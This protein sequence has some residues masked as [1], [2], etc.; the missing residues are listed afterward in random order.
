MNFLAMVVYAGI[1]RRTER[2][3]RGAVEL[4]TSLWC[5]ATS[6]GTG[7][8]CGWWAAGGGRWA[9]G[10]G[11]RWS[12]ATGGRGGG[13]RSVGDGPLNGRHPAPPHPRILILAMVH[14]SPTRDKETCLFGKA[15][16]AA[17]ATGKASALLESPLRGRRN[18]PDAARHFERC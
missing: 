13:C 7:G 2:A 1:K 8:C 18:A 12:L 14:G 3:G 4:N 6:L 9:V 16:K 5:H 17:K 10:S 15:T 11:G